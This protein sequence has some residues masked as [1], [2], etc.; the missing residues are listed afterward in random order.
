MNTNLCKLILYIKPS[1]YHYLV[2]QTLNPLK[3]KQNC[4]IFNKQRRIYKCFKL[5]VLMVLR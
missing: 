3:V 2:T 1:S 4:L 5:H